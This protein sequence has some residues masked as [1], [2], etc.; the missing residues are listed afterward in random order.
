MST[1]SP[2]SPR[3]ST[4]KRGPPPRFGD[5]SPEQ[6]L[7]VRKR[8]G[9]I[10]HDL[11]DKPPLPQ[12]NSMVEL[13]SS[14]E[15]V[16][17]SPLVTNSTTVHQDMEA[18]GSTVEEHEELSDS[19]STHDN[20]LK[21]ILSKS[22][23]YKRS[24]L[25]AR[26]VSAKEAVI[27]LRK[28]NKG[29]AR[30]CQSK[31]T[32]IESLEKKIRKSEDQKLTFKS[33]LMESVCKL[34]ESASK[35]TTVRMENK[36]NSEKLVRSNEKLDEIESRISLDNTAREE[37]FKMKHEREVGKLRLENTELKLISKFESQKMSYLESENRDLF[38]KSKKYDDVA[39]AYHK[40]LIQLSAFDKKA[41]SRYLY[42]K[43]Y[44]LI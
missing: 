40:S 19:S 22:K 6:S 41:Q 38:A 43:N 30:G 39:T 31:S 21:K 4:R 27:S 35:L 26:W 14:T 29:L 20:K 2:N 8:G 25:Y 9:L 33:K 44:S 16:S 1:I 32:Y 3:T 24:D 42:F 17:S 37:T 5:S 13:P 34:K 28:I 36:Y 7:N 15:S 23:N 10:S 18:E 11:I 12:E